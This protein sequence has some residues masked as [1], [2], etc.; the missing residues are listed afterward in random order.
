ME[1][2]DD[3]VRARGGALL[4]FAYVLCGDSHRAE[5]FVQEALLRCSRKW[6]RI[7]NGAGPD[8]YVR[9][10]ILRQYLSWR[11]RKSAAEHVSD[12]IE[13]ADRRRDASDS[14]GER[15]AIWRML[16]QLP[17]RQRAVLVLRFYEDLPTDEIA[18]LL[19]MRPATVR[20]HA[21]RGLEQLRRH[22]DLTRDFS[23]VKEMT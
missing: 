5:D 19:G 17:R 23:S 8:A 13:P 9:K 11:R 2:F 22:P 7:E 14:L 21:S 6:R 15:D 16:V 12:Q 20:V 10:A 18:A 4:R 1:N 3:Y